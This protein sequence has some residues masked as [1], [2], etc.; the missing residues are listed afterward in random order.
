MSV[1]AAV[2]FDSDGLLLDTEVLWTR[3]EEKLFAARG[4]RFTPAQKLQ[5]V[6][7]STQT[8]GIRLEAML[9]EPGGAAEIMEEL[10]ALVMAEVA[11]GGEPM[12]GARELVG[13]LTAAATPLALVSNSP[14][15]FVSAVLAPSGLAPAFDAVVTPGGGLAPKPSPDVYLE[16]CRRL[17]VAPADCVALEDSA[18]GAAAAAAAGIPVIG[19]PSVPGVELPAVDLLAA[20][21]TA[22]EV[23]E[24]VGL[25]G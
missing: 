24:A 16:A 22:R 20:S 19:V 12:P 13:A 9:E 6:G 7:T 15:A 10:H 1:C 14:P 25:L 2:L 18:P 17:D 8:A 4:R 23:W 5:L 21:L 3:A 11:G